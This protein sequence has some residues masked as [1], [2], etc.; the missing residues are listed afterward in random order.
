MSL[1]DSFT[2]PQWQHRKPEVR[3]AA[4][5]QLDDPAV[6]LELVKTDPDPEVRAHA[7]SRING[8]DQ[9][10]ELIDTIPPPLQQQAKNQRLQQLLPD[11]KALPSITDDTVLIRIAGLSEDLDLITA[12]IAQ[13]GSQDIRMDLAGNH[14]V[15]RVRLSAAQGIEDIDL[16]QQL[17]LAAKHKDKA[18]F[19]HCKEK[20][21]QHHAIEQAET[22]RQVTI[23]QLIEK[24]GQLS[25]S[26]FSPE[27]KGR[28]LALEQKW[29]PLKT[30]VSPEQL[31]QI[32]SALEIC[33]ALT[34][35]HAET[36]AAEVEQKSLVTDAEQ[37][38]P[39]LI[40]ELEEIDSAAAP[41]LDSTAISELNNKLNGI[42]DR[43][44]AALRHAK[45]TSEQTDDCKKHLKNWRTMASTA[46]ALRSRKSQL[47]KN[48]EESGKLDKSDFLALQQQ[49]KHTQKLIS[50]LPWP[51]SHKAISPPPLQQLQERLV[52][53]EERM[54]TLRQKEKQN[55]EQL[56]LKFAELRKELETNHFKNADRALNKLRQVLRKLDPKHQQ[57]YQHELR[58]LIA[59]LNE[60][61]DWQGFAIEPKK[62]ELCERMKALAGSEDSAEVLARQ[63]KALQDEWKKLGA[64]SPR[65]DQALWNQFKTAADVAYEPCKEAFAQKAVLCQQN[66]EQRMLLIAQLADYEKKMA[67][68]DRAAV[69]KDPDS[70]PDSELDSDS[71]SEGAAPNWKMVQKTLDTAREAFKNIKP[72]DHKGERKSQKKFRKICDRIYAHIK[73]EYERNIALKNELVS[74]AQSLAGLE[75]LHQAIDQAKK[76]QRE[77]KEVG[78]TPVRVDRQL[79]KE[80]RAACDAVFARLDEQRQQTHQAMSA[81]IEQAESLIQK[82]QSLLDSEDDEQRLH[83]KRDL[84]EIRAALREIELPRNVQQKVIKRLSDLEQ[85]S[86]DIISEIRHKTERESWHHLAEKMKA[87]ALKIVDEKKA[88][89]CWQQ[90]SPLPK[91]IDG[92]ALENFWQQGPGDTAEQELKEGCIALEI[93]IGI[94]SPA[95]DKDARMAYQMKRLVEGMGSGPTDTKQQLLEQINGFIAMRPATEWL[96]RFCNGVGAAKAEK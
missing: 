41:P 83:L 62:I 87:C 64:L 34:Q 80:F 48:Q 61:H 59:R 82:A 24:A 45:A 22:E 50:V 52:R 11:S 93:L 85:K 42:E 38:F 75:D 9:L 73:R 35:E 8:G 13:V 78:M 89:D 43:W 92:E 2:K 71:D 27:Y 81:Q 76:I 4:I 77:W 21:D 29:Q 95:E 14:P 16:L 55:L 91:G 1:I 19:R 96:E 26:V 40:S 20:L 3:I 44:L 25:K 15:A 65:R 17:A 39:E 86:R 33:A 53:L 68:P 94:D 72:V 57:R 31:Q 63:I 69:V 56:E 90:D 12:A 66:Y 58:P 79:W 32:E 7:L 88:A 5:D 18:V 23:Q 84:A 70:A 36:Q 60:I 54:E 67:W 37:S 51:D 30:Q 49:Y 28:Y 47:E 74:R 10:D 6:L 46:Q